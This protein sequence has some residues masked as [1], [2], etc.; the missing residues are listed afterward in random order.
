MPKRKPARAKPIK[1]D[2]RVL[3]LAM[4][5]S[6]ALR[7]FKNKPIFDS[8]TLSMTTWHKWFKDSLKEAGYEEGK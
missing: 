4:C 3:N 1:D 2:P 7:S 6:F 8:N 5:V